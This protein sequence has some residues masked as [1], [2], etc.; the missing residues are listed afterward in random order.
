MFPNYD[1]I[2]SRI[3]EDPT[4]YTKQGV[5][6]YG[7][8]KPAE[9]NIYA[10]YSLLMEI[11]C[12]DCGKR[13]LIGQDYDGMDI[14]KV[15]LD[16]SKIEPPIYDL[17]KDLWISIR[18]GI[19][20]PNKLDEN[21]NHQYKTLTLKDLIEGWAFGDPPNHGCVGDTMGSIEI[22]CVQAW[23]LRFGQE[24]EDRTADNGNTYSVIVKMGTPTRITELEEFKFEIPEWYRYG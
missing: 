20:A 10:Y 19:Y 22:R 11:G 14:V 1:D 15:L 7:E 3:T 18:H 4:W 2:T 16:P 13:F 23:D 21:G 12:Q 24:T 5:P 6:R 9:C 8:F 17:T